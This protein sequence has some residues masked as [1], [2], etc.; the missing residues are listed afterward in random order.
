MLGTAFHRRHEE[1]R[2][3]APSKSTIRAKD[4]G[5]SEVVDDVKVPGAV[6]DPLVAP[7]RRCLASRKRSE[8]SHESPET[9]ARSKEFEMCRGASEPVSIGRGGGRRDVACS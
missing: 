6:R 9:H 4:V 7:Y 1:Q 2:A 3:V 8:D 5:A